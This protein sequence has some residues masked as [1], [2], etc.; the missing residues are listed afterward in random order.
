MIGNDRRDM[1]VRSPVASPGISGRRKC[2]TCNLGKPELGGRV[3]PRTRMW[4][5][6]GCSST[7][8]TKR[9]KTT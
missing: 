9:P 6:A 8:E 7:W 2:W 3:H 5:C 1:T 4:H